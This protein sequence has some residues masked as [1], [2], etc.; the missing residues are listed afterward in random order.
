MLSDEQKLQIAD[1]FI[2]ETDKGANF[3][4]ALLRAF[5]KV[6]SEC[7]R[8]IPVEDRNPEEDGE[9]M[10]L[11]S[12]GSRMFWVFHKRDWQPSLFDDWPEGPAYWYPD[13]PAPEVEL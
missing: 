2:E 4:L 13:L 11:M 8:W 7:L 6:E 5:K 12:D 10:V 9:Y 1:E 3:V